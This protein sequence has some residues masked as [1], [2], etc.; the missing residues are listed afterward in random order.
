[1]DIPN[2]TLI[3]ISKKVGDNFKGKYRLVTESVVAKTPVT[4]TPYVAPQPVVESTVITYS[5]PKVE[6][7]IVDT[8]PVIDP[9]APAVQ[10]INN[11]EV[12]EPTV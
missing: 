11:H 4:V 8:E 3:A 6:A 9:S 5:P 7:V 1:M 2:Q 10:V 12:V